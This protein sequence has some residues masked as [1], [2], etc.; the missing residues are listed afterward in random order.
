MEAEKDKLHNWCGEVSIPGSKLE[1]SSL[2]TL[3][4]N[5]YFIFSDSFPKAQ[6]FRLCMQRNARR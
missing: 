3:S 6:G 1:E 4:T 2:K 5:H